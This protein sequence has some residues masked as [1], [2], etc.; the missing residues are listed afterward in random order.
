MLQWK[1]RL[2]VVAAILTPVILA[3]GGL[4]GGELQRYN[5]YW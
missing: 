2:V 1:P 4:F 3:L 5:L